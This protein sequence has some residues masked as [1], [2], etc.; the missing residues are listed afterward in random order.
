MYL[1]MYL[2]DLNKYKEILS[3]PCSKTIQYY[4]QVFAGIKNHLFMAGMYVSVE[5]FKS[6]Y[7]V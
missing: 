6:L 3:T 4:G 5:R 2:E 1:V 7:F